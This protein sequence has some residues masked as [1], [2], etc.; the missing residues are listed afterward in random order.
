MKNNW[1]Y[2]LFWNKHYCVKST[3]NLDRKYT[4][5][6][7]Y[8]KKTYYGTISKNED[9][10]LCYRQNMSVSIYVSLTIYSNTAIDSPFPCT[11]VHDVIVL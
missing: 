9:H 7:D 5:S 6:I 1:I 3:S 4:E 8:S 11:F 2:E 10:T